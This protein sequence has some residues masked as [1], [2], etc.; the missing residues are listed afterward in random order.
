[1][2]AKGDRRG[3][4]GK[5]DSVNDRGGDK[6]SVRGDKSNRPARLESVLPC[7]KLTAEQI[8]KLR[9]F[10]TANRDCEKAARDQFRATIEPIRQQQKTAI[11]AIKE[12]VKAGT[13]T[14]A[15][16][17]TQIEALNSSLKPAVQAAE[18]AMKA[19]LEA[20]R[21]SLMAN[22]ESILTPEQLVIWM[23]WKTTGKAPCDPRTIGTRG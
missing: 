12:Q 7:L 20:C 14:K 5:R 19:A 16:A 11:D 8:A 18:A 17:R 3:P 9:E 22:I 1:M 4:G 15:D 13:L 10:M 6:D 23:Q 21:A 2:F